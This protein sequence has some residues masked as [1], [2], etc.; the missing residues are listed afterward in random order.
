MHTAIQNL[1]TAYMEIGEHRK[2]IELLHHIVKKERDSA[3]QHTALAVP[4]A[5]LSV[6]HYYNGDWERSVEVAKETLQHEKALPWEGMIYSK[7][8]NKGHIGDG[9]FVLSMICPL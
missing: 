8:P 7:P 9:P 2:S 5:K 4:L 6:A 1:A 3:Q